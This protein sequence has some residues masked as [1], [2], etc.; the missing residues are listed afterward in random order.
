MQQQNKT[1]AS[2]TEFIE[3]PAVPFSFPRL[4]HPGK[5]SATCA[6]VISE[7]TC[8]I[9]TPHVGDFGGVRML[10]NLG[11]GELADFR[12]MVGAGG[13]AH[14]DG[15]STSILLMHTASLAAPA[16]ATRN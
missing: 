9:T 1:V 8:V 3:M 2:I 6:M 11:P 12:S 14:A 4:P 15:P 5:K 16:S 7:N 10:L 13:L